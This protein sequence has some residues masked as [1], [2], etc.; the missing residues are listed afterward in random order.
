MF[1][2]LAAGKQRALGSSVLPPHPPLSFFN[3]MACSRV[4]GIKTAAAAVA[5]E[6]VQF[7][8]AHKHMHIPLSTQHGDHTAAGTRKRV[9]AHT[10]SVKY[11]HHQSELANTSAR[12]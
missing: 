8:K 3:Q 6:S 10:E 12:A 7:W 1:A 4:E 9:D 5:D 11:R 2:A